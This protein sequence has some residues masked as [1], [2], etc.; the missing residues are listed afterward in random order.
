MHLQFHLLNFILHNC[1]FFFLKCYNL[2]MM[3]E[4][5]IS[6]VMHVWKYSSKLKTKE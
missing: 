2:T 6:S 5:S 1:D 3:A 4:A